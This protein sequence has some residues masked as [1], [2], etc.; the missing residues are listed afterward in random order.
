MIMPLLYNHDMEDIYIGKGKLA[1]KGLFANRDFKK[2]ELV[3]RW[4]LKPLSQEQFDALPKS[5]HMFVHS[6]GGRMFLFPEPSRYTNH[7]AMPT[8]RSDFEI[9]CDYAIRDIQKGEPI[10]IN[11]TDEIKY[12]LST[13]L[14][15]YEEAINSRDFKKVAPL[16]ANN[17][18]YIFTNGTHK[19]KQAIQEE[20]E[21]T[22]ATIL[23]ERYSLS[24]VKWVKAGYRNAACEYAFESDG[25]IDGKRQVHKGTGTSTLRR[26]DGNWRIVKEELSA[27]IRV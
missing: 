21:E 25:V 23:D 1:G 16:V 18:E 26:I 13:F 24:K 14:K 8:L 5:E 9:Q 4:N 11:A 7:S 19:G 22:W 20:F 2:G 15:T 12:E 6:F 27:W 10:T 17:A 3:K